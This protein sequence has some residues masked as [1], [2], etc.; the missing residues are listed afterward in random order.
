MLASC[1]TLDGF[2]R[3]SNDKNGLDLQTLDAGV[4]LTVK[5]R[6]SSYRLVVLDSSRQ[7]VLAEGGIFPEPTVVRVSGATFGGSTLKV[8]WILVGLRM[9]FGLGAKQITSSPVQCV[10]VEDPALLT[11][12]EQYAA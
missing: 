7:L 10:T 3:E 5:T 12:H 8:G 2:A 9:E 4:A 1:R 6:R 11:A